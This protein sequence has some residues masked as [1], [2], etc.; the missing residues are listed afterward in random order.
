MIVGAIATALLFMVGKS[1]IGW[2][3]GTSAVASTYGA[4]GALI[5]VLLWVYYT[6]QIF[7]LGAEFTKVYSNRFGS[8]KD[9][10]PA[11]LDGRAFGRRGASGSA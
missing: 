5:V 7:L 3:L 1:I 2:Y 9:R 10:N 4:A 11:H 6:S 8:Q